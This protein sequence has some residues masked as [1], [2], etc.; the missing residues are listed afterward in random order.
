M[1]QAVKHGLRVQN[2]LTTTL[3]ERRRE[4]QSHRHTKEQYGVQKPRM[5]VGASMTFDWVKNSRPTSDI[6]WAGSKWKPRHPTPGTNKPSGEEAKPAMIDIQ[7][8]GRLVGAILLLPRLS[9]A[10]L[11]L[12]RVLE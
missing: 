8:Q 4:N 5:R 6:K 7:A 11:G 3:L 9:E 2:M 1:G 12:R 10:G